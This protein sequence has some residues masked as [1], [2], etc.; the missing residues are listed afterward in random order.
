AAIEHSPREDWGDRIA[1]LAARIEAMPAPSDEWR[2]RVAELGARIDAIPA[3]SDEWRRELAQ[4]ADNL[5]IRIER[6]EQA[7]ADGEVG[8]LRALVDRRIDDLSGRLDAI[9]APTDEWRSRIAELSGRVDAI[10]HRPAESWGDRVAE[11][12]AR[13]DAIPAPTDEWRHELA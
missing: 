2:S 11:L 9:P 4:V 5:R 3:P 13:L 1:G 7:P 10:E 6:V 12:A 8:E